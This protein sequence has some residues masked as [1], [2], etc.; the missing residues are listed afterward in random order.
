MENEK[1]LVLDVK[2]EPLNFQRLT[3]E[4]PFVAKENQQELKSFDSSSPQKGNQRKYFSVR[5][6]I[7]LL[8]AL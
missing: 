1:L 2:Y 8:A 4:T 5:L 7:F 6:S 3:I